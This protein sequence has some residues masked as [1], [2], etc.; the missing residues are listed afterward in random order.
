M[1]EN[2]EVSFTMAEDL[3]SVNIALSNEERIKLQGRIDRID[4]YKEGE[5][6]YVKV[7]DYKS[8]SKKF[9]LA[10]LYYGLQLQLAV[11]MNAAVEMEKRKNPGKKIIPAALLYYRVT[12]PMVKSDGEMTEEEL[13]A[14]IKKELSMT[15]IVNKSDAVITYLDKE[16]TDKSDILPLERKKDGA[17]SVRSSVISEEDL[18]EISRYVNRKIKE[19][20][21]EI[22]DGRIEASPCRQGTELACDFCSF[23]PVCG[24]DGRIPGYRYRQLDGLKEEEAMMKIREEN[25]KE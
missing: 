3:E 14:K 12:D 5:N 23:R 4:T 17:L 22:L 2:V 8:G 1:P 24:F 18:Q 25:A 15:G 10:A 19:A 16:F 9:N 13:D 7:I 11:Y 6:V 21:R 20:G